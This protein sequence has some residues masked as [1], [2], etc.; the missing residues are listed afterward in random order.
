MKISLWKEDIG[1]AGAIGAA[2]LALALIIGGIDRNS[3]QVTSKNERASA[4]KKADVKPA[5]QIWLRMP[6][7]CEQWI[8]MR[9]A[10][11]KWKNRPACADL[12]AREGK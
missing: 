10:G 3:A 5:E 7:E 6:L 12:T 4:E 11:E 9:G 1:A 2:A 8:A